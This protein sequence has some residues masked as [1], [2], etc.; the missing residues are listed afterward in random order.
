VVQPSH[1]I[2]F[3]IT[4]GKDDDTNRAIFRS[5][6][7]CNR[8]SVVLRQPYVEDQRIKVEPSGQSSAA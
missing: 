8:E 5:E 6:R 3:G 1:H 2:V 7:F 4:G